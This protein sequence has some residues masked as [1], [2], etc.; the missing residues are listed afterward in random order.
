LPSLLLALLIAA[1]ALNGLLAGASL[2]QSLKQLR[3]RHKL[4]ADAFSAYLRAADL[5]P[6][7]LFYATLGIGAAAATIAFALAVWWAA[8]AAQTL[9]IPAYGAGILSVL[10]SIVTAFAAPVNFSQRR[11]PIGAGNEKPI[12]RILDR[13]ARLQHLRSALQ[14]ATFLSLLCAVAISLSGSAILTRP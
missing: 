7:V 2:D 11:Y 13:F 12:A 9:R 14:V 3:A 10:H 6:G 5:G 1:L 4:G 8:P